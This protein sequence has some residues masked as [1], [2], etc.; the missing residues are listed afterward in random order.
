MQLHIKVKDFGTEY[1]HVIVEAHKGNW[2]TRIPVMWRARFDRAESAQEL[3]AM[4]REEAQPIF[5]R[6]NRAAVNHHH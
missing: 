1:Q 5:E 2:R 4:Y 3:E 6:L